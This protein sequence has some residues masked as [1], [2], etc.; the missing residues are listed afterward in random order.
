MIIKERDSKRIEIEKLKSLLKNGRLTDKQKNSI[1]NEIN[2]IRK[3]QQGE[4]QVSFYID[5]YLRN[6]KNWAVIHDLRINHKGSVAQIDH[7]LVNRLFYIFAIETKNI[8]GKVIINN[9]GEFEVENNGKRY[10]IESPI[11]QN[12]RHIRVLE[13]FFRDNGIINKDKLLLPVKIKFKNLIVFS[14]ETKI[15]RPPKSKFD[16]SIVIKSDAFQERF[17]NEIENIPI[18]DIFLLKQIVSSEKLK[19]ICEKIVSHHE[20]ISV[21]FERK[22][23]IKTRESKTTKYFCYKCKKDIDYECAKYC[24]S[25]KDIFDGRAFCIKCQHKM[26]AQKMNQ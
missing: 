1:R 23:G 20:P 9:Y 19:E 11:N 15:K 14:K 24:W 5:D 4:K 17:T 18:T 12:K 7:L 6:S 26:R 10:G 21:N 2:I 8:S 16:T 3:G 22:F 25:H 13:N